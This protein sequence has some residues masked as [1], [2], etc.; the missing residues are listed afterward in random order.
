MSETPRWFKSSRSNMA[1]NCVEVAITDTFSWFTSGFGALK[2]G[3]YVEVAF[4]DATTVLMRDT[5]NRDAAVLSIGSGEWS[6][7]TRSVSRG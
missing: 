7:W 4:P 3:E 5:R 6:G 1:S 2:G